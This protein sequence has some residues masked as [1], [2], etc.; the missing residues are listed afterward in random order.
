MTEVDVSSR[1][2]RHQQGSRVSS[3]SLFALGEHSSDLAPDFERATVEGGCLSKPIN[4]LPVVHGRA[5]IVPAS[6]E[7]EL[8]P[9][10]SAGMTPPVG[11][12][13]FWAKV[14]HSCFHLQLRG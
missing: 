12:S 8:A 4:S 3:Y 14:V 10:S 1:H 11:L 2:L 9:V 6:L 7:S 5:G 13:L